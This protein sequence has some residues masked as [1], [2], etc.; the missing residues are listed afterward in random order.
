M[1]GAWQID[2]T[3]TR[4]NAKPVTARFTIQALK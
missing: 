3:V 2:A 1:K 4:T